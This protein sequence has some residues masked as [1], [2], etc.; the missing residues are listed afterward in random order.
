MRKIVLGVLLG[1]ILAGPVWAAEEYKPVHVFQDA[2]AA[3]SDGTALAVAGFS[4]IGL[5]IVITDTA[6][7]AFEATTDGSNWVASVCSSVASTS[8]ALV[9][10]A[11][12]SGLYKCNVAG[13]AQFRARIS[14]FTGGTVTVKGLL[15]VAKAG[16][17]SGGG[18]GGSITVAE[19][20]GDPDVSGVS[21]LTVPNGLLTDDGSGA[22]SL[23]SPTVTLDSAFDN[24]KVID[25]ATSEANGFCVG[26]DAA[27]KR[28]CIWHDASTGLHILPDEAADTKTEIMTNQTWS[29]FDVEGDA[30]VETIDPDAASTLAMWTYGTAYRPKKSVWFG[31][32][33]LSTDGTQCAAPAEA[34]PVASGPKVWS[35]I[36]TDNDGSTIHGAVRMPDS[37]DAGT[38]TFTHVYQQTA[39]DTSALNGDIAAQCRGNGEAP[40]STYGTE[41]AIDDAAVVGSGANDMTTSAAV[42]P[43]GTCAAGDMLYWRYQ[44]DATGTTT[45]VATL[46][47][48]GFNMEYSITSRSD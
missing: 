39:A 14:A 38:V 35:I 29:L 15:T 22:V 6:T 41:V 26:G 34:T 45:A 28:V 8:G 31:A 30:N 21:T 9:S 18:G 10:S 48:L 3:T 42:T 17:A 40:S 19:E 16:G 7:V 2:A 27:S 24:G 25:G 11:T 4:T 46:H 37:W 5:Q 32:G 12:A 44:L 13:M 1:L 43:T 20:D 36:C 23:A 47:H 33:S